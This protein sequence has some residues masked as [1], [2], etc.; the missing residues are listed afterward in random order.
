MKPF[1]KRLCPNTSCVRTDHNFSDRI[2]R[3]SDYFISAYLPKAK[4]RFGKPGVRQK[5]EIKRSSGSV[6]LLL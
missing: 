5:I 6:Y 2:P 1:M 3:S 4:H